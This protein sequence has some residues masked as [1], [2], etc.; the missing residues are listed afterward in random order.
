MAAVARRQHGLIRIDQ[1]HAAG[2]STRAVRGRVNA[3]RLYRVHRGV[4]SLAPPPLSRH[5]IWLGAVLACGTDALLSHEPAAILQGFLLDG[6]LVPEITVPGGSG[7]SREGI[8]VHRSLVDTRDRRRVHGI[9][10]VSA[11]R[12][13]VDL[14]PAHEPA[15]L[16]TLLVAAESLGLLKRGRLAELVAERRGRPGMKRLAEL[17]EERP[18]IA[19]SWPE[20][21]FL[22]VCRLAGVPHPL[23]NHPVAVPDAGRP[24]V[25]DFA[26]P[27]IALAVELDSQRFHGDWA[28]AV[29]D[30]E[31]DQLLALAG[32][33]CR[34][35]VRSVVEADHVAAAGRL[36]SLHAMRLG[37]PH[38][39]SDPAPRAAEA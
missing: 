9:P 25:V 16:E 13:L 11:D 38:G 35:F 8:V 24:I 18:A 12:I 5:Q 14:A 37:L 22:P 4:Y 28:A 31:R 15:E 27:E 26:W 17:L 20:V 19:R 1:L 32:W 36:R 3:G 30:R 29:R 7:R 21:H 33:E 10:C 2:L 6:S 23:Q 34:R 39:G